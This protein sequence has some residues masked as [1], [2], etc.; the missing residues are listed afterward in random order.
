MKSQQKS[1]KIHF[2]MASITEQELLTHIFDHV[3]PFA[4]SLGMNEQVQGIDDIF[5]VCL[6]NVL[7]LL[8]IFCP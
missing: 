4:D 3:L 8:Y 2:E 5:F 7:Y 6:V 1:T